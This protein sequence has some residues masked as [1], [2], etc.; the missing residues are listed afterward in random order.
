ME[1]AGRRNNGLKVALEVLSRRK[2]L[3]IL[4][5]WR[6][7]AAVASIVMFLPNVYWANANDHRAPGIPEEFVKSTVTSAVETRTA[8]DQPRDLEP[9]PAGEPDYRF[10]LYTHLRERVPLEQWLSGYGKTSGLELKRVERV[11]RDQAM[12]LSPSV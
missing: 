5:F 1:E 7:F 10:E 3:A 2:W 12:A 6:R 9:L 11:G 8:D 4:I